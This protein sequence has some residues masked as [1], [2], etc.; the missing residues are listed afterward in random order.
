MPIFDMKNIPSKSS[1][2]PEKPLIMLVDD[3]AENLNVMRQ[4][5]AADFQVITALS[6]YEAIQII[7]NMGDA[8]KIQ[9]IISD[10]RMPKMSGVE[11][12]KLVADKIPDTIRIILS[13]YSDTQ[14]VIDSINKAEIYKFMTKPFDPGELSLTVKR[15][16][17]AFQMRQQLFKYSTH[18]EK[19]VA[20]RTQE[21][22]Q[23]N[24]ELS[25][26]LHALEQLS[27]SDQLTGAYNR[28]FLDKFMPQEINQFKRKYKRHLG[29]RG[30]FGIMMIDIDHFKA[31]N[32]NYGH[33]AGDKL[34][35]GF[36]KMLQQNCREEDWVVRWGGE[37]FVIITR[38]LSLT[39][40]Q[41][42]AERLRAKIVSKEFDIGC[43]QKLLKTCSMGLVCFPFIKNSFNALSW[44]QTL[45]LA[46]L[47]LYQAKNNGRNT[48]VSLCNAHLTQDEHLYENIMNNLQTLIGN[49]LISYH[50]THPGSHIT[51][52]TIKHG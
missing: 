42:L 13:A 6:G 49:N 22:H 4:L 10:Q 18:L 14:V 35:V 29:K 32:D 20:E 39:G 48:W 33:D 36:T 11:F 40:Q 37:E 16:V 1:R 19:L 34:L 5:L 7:N 2:P 31:V 8:G 43:G 41:C 15:G 24:E 51:F 26:A 3:E 28:H 23:K 21:L 47:A 17:E 27:L 52:N 25:Q 45:N 50:S 9:L 38:G 46:D 12:L 30:Y 44:Q